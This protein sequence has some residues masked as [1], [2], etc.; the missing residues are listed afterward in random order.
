I[1]GIVAVTDLDAMSQM[2]REQVQFASDD[3]KRE[4]FVRKMELR[5]EAD[6]ALIAEIVAVTDLDAMSQMWRE[7]VQFA[8]DD[9]KREYF[10]RK[11][12]LRAQA[13]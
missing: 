12:E 10:V 5:A 7:Q 1:A 13:S 2:W 11:M 3:V 4:Y 9:V 8:S 6:K